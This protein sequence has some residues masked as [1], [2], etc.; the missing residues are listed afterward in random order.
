LNILLTGGAGYIGS[1]TAVTLLEAG[2]NVVVADNLCNS[3]QETLERIRQI[4]QKEIP[5]YHIDVTEQDKVNSIFASHRLDGVVHFAGLKAVGESVEKPLT[6]YYNN[7]VCTMVL[8]KACLTLLGTAIWNTVLVVL[9][10]FAGEAWESVL[11]YIDRY[12]TIAL[13]ALLLVILLAVFRFY[14]HKVNRK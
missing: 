13:I 12:S 2:H 11:V 1:H 10:S 7:V 4:T 14:R 3:N 9:G 8:A 6:Y 5:F